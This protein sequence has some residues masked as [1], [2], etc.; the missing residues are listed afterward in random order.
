MSRTVIVAYK[1][2]PGKEKQLDRLM[3]DHV[4]RLRKE[5]LATDRQSI[6]MKAKDGTV[7]EVFEWKSKEAIESAHTNQAVLKM[8]E[9][10]ADVCEFVPVA[11]LEEASEMFSEFASFE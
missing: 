1:P 5:G 4:P 7:V 11:T 3:K 2:K 6:L 10:F 8:W 9:E